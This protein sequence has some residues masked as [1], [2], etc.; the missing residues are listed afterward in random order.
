MILVTTLSRRDGVSQHAVREGT[1]VYFLKPCG[2]L[3]DPVVASSE[4][5]SVEEQVESLA[6][7]GTIHEARKQKDDFG[8]VSS[9]RPQIY[10][11]SSICVVDPLGHC[12][13]PPRN[14]FAS[15]R[16]DT[17]PP[18]VGA[19]RRVA[20]GLWLTAPASLVLD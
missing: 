16:R 20:Q 14:L 7:A 6:N 10:I 4:N 18:P 19:T 11:Y 3:L 13:S 12:V 8:R 5:T 2:L 17:P 9:Y 15:R 1:W